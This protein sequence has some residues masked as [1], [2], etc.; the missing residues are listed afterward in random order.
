MTANFV[1]QKLMQGILHETI[2]HPR[3]DHGVGHWARVL[4]IGMRLSELNQANPRVVQLFAVFHDSQRVS[5]FDDPK[6]GLRGAKLAERLR[7]DLFDLPD[8]EFALLYEACEH[9][10]AGRTDGQCT[11]QTCWDADRLD[12]GRVG[13]TPAPKYFGTRIL[14]H[15]ELVSWAHLRATTRVLPAWVAEAWGHEVFETLR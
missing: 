3:G 1:S 4:D 12:L 11:V 2:L 9:H 10:T 13:L 5:D 7:G 6:H 15:P 8:D 14:D